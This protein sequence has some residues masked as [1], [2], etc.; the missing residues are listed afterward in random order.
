MAKKLIVNGNVNTGNATAPEFDSFANFELTKSVQVSSSRSI[1]NRQELPID[2]EHDV[3]ELQFEDRSTWIG[4]AQEFQ[5]IFDITGKRGM[6][7]EEDTLEIPLSL[8]MANE[9]GV[10]Q[11]VAVSVFNL[12]KRKSTAI[13]GFAVHE[14]AEKLEDKVQPQPGLFYLDYSFRKTVA[15]SFKNTNK[16]YLLFI[17]G[18]NSNTEGAFGGLINNKAGGMWDFITNTYGENILAFDHKTLTHSALQNAQQLLELLPANCTVHLITHSRGGLVGDIIARADASNNTIGFT[19]AEIAA[20]E[21]RPADVA[22]MKAIIKVATEK[23]ITVSKCIRVASPSMGT[24]L[25]ADRLDHYL[26]TLLNFI[27][28]STGQAAN[29]IYIGT[30][31]LL[32]EVASSKSNTDVLPGLEAMMPESPFI[33]IL[34]NPANIINSPLVIIAGN[35][36]VHLELKALLVI[37][38]KLYFRRKN[39]MVVDTWSMYFGTPR[40]AAVQFYLDDDKGVDHVHYFRNNESQEAMQ[41]AL[42]SKE[43]TIPGFKPLQASDISDASRNAAL[44]FI[45]SEVKFDLLHVTGNKPIAVIIPGIMGSNL[46]KDDNRIWVDF[47]SFVKGDL[48]KLDINTPAITA[49]SLMGS[50]YKKL[51][52]ELT[53]QYDVVAFAFDWRQSLTDEA[54]KF[55]ATI[56]FL[57]TKKQPIHVLA[58]SMGGVLFREFMLHGSNWTGLNTSNQFRALFLGAPLGGSYLIPETFTGRGGNINK[59]SMIDLKHDKKDLL[60]VFANCPGLYNLLPLSDTPHNFEDKQLWQNIIGS[61]GNIGTVPPDSM[62][63]KFAAFKK[64]VLANA[65]SLDYSNIFYV[66]GKADATTATFEMDNTGRPNSLVFKSTSEGDGSVTWASGIP[67]KMIEKDKVYYAASTTHGELGNDINLFPAFIDLLKNGTTNLLRKT[68]PVSRGSNA[69]VNNPKFE[70][71]PINTNNI[72]QV[73]LGMQ[74]EDKIATTESLLKISISNGDLRDAS[75]PV[76]SGHFYKDGILYAESVLDS[77]LNGVLRERHALNL[78]PGDVGTH[79]IIFSWTTSP[80]GAVIVGLGELGELNAYKLELS[81]T[82][83]VSKLLL[84]L[85]ELEASNPKAYQ[86]IFKNGIGI[87]A[88]IVGCGFGGLS[89]DSSLRAIVMGVK[90]AN[91]NIKA[92]NNPHLKKIEA[93]EFVELYE[94]RALQAFYSL[95]RL[96]GDQHLNIV[97]PSNKIKKMFGVKKRVPMDLQSDWWQRVSVEIV[98]GKQHDLLKFSASTGSAREELRNLNSN[99]KIIQYFIDEI[100]AKNHWSDQLAKTI[101]ELLIPN[102]FKDSVRNQYNI[103][104]RL[105]KKAAAFPWEML[106]DTSM[107]SMPLC[108]TSGMIRQLATG[109]FRTSI[110]RSYKNNCLVIGD[111][112]LKGFVH[113]LPGAAKEAT[114][115]AGI[116]AAEGFNVTSKINTNFTEVIQALFQ[117]EYKMIHLAGHGFFDPENPENAGMV[118]GDHLFLTSKEINQMSQVPEFVFV[119]CCYL[120]KVDGEAE[121]KSQQRYQ[122]AAN[123]GVQLIEMGVKA[124]VAAGWAVDDTSALLF[125]ETFYQQMFDGRPFGEAVKE[126]RCACYVNNKK[127]NTWGA[128]QCYGD[129][130]YTLSSVK[131]QGNKEKNYTLPIEIEIDLNNLANKV[132][133]GR[134]KKDDLLK[135][136]EKTSKAIEKSGLRDGAITELEARIYGALNEKDIAI[137]KMNSLLTLENA[138]YSVKTL[139]NLFSLKISMLRNTTNKTA[140][141][142]IA[143]IKSFETVLKIGSTAE[144]HLL[145]GKAYTVLALKII[146]EDQEKANSA[147][148]DEK[149]K[150]KATAKNDEGKLTAIQA[151]A[152]HF[153]TSFDIAKK[154]K[155]EELISLCNWLQAEKLLIL[156]NNKPTVQWG[157]LSINGYKLPAIKIAMEWMEKYL[158][159][160]NQFQTFSNGD[161]VYATANVLL[162]KLCMEPSGKVK[163]ADI[164]SLAV[165]SWSNGLFVANNHLNTENLDFLQAVLIGEKATG[166]AA[167]KKNIDEVKIKMYEKG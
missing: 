119:N 132:E 14:I 110:K 99:P 156:L 98:N 154:N 74:L 54:Q 24:S 124:V 165:S 4:N 71:V 56:A 39:D 130:F 75:F 138:S 89:I 150:T 9:R 84:R 93:I 128:Y 53:K 44:P 123:I 15:T 16:P 117:D 6:D 48:I 104:W 10:L 49:P 148:S 137:T 52:N 31:T 116:V 70:M 83:G 101:F 144:R 43:E 100:S 34:N 36:T 127:N 29:P 46:Y 7:E 103:L 113:Q 108:V 120:G 147:S 121:A 37:L 58:H 20:L 80:K 87:S 42:D 92:L 161:G 162:T 95:K 33:K 96:E 11:D 160:D 153:K 30:K 55:D 167:L 146:G 78:Y 8:S 159:L 38:T 139:E 94:D 67:K 88:L 21:G 19:D 122:L 142:V 32:S 45:T 62:I 133:G 41:R 81:V 131:Q 102:D 60:Q 77:Y 143:A 50:A 111:P 166:A 151:A 3:V 51:Y 13:V 17:H 106:Q 72:E 23:R 76:I 22:C 61:S 69:L 105:D 164:A 40:K 12:F 65:E 27:G 68:P 1:A 90:K 5:E 135:D 141:D 129:Q 107:Q 97:L 64:N 155:K 114:A 136:L 91:E 63:K 149:G 158:E 85:R 157:K 86:T 18:T 57:L 140:D 28:I 126:A 73:V 125:A 112:D 82:Q 47:W 26:N 25:L 118:I 115:V 109:D 79:E 163:P 134:H 152:G 35:C 66:A 59:L 145:L 2:G